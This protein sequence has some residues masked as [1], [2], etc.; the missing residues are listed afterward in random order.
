MKHTSRWMGLG[1][2]L[3]LSIIT[4][5]CPS[6]EDPDPNPP[7]QDMTPDLDNP[8]S[9]ADTPVDQPPT[10]TVAL[11]S[12]NPRSGSIHGGTV[13]TLSGA[14]FTPGAQ[15][16]FGAT[17]ATGVEVLSASQ[18]R[19]TSPAGDLGPVDVTVRVTGGAEATLSGGFTYTDGGVVTPIFCNLQPQPGLQASAGAP[20]PAIYA[21][22]FVDGVTQGLGRGD[23]LQVELGYGMGANAQNFTYSTMSYNVD[24]DGLTPGDRS[25]DEYQGTLTLPAA[26][27]F[28]YAARVRRSG[29]PDWT[30]C[31]LDGSE[32]G[33]S[34]DQLGTITVTAPSISYCQLAPQ[35]PLQARPG[36]ASAPI[37]AVV[38]AAGI[39][40]G[41]GQGQGL[42]A[43][44]GLGGV[45]DDVADFDFV[46][47]SYTADRDGLAGGDRANDEYAAALT[48]ADVGDYR[49]VAR[50]RV[51]GDADWFYCD[52]DGHGADSPFDPAQA[53]V[54]EVVAEPTP[55]IGYCLTETPTLTTR[56]GVATAP[57]RGLTYAQGI[58]DSVGAGAG[59]LAEV[60]WGP[61]DVDPSAWTAIVSAPYLEDA[62]GLNPN[63]L[64]ND[65]HAATL[66]PAN[67]GSFGYLYRFRLDA[68]A[69]WTWCGLAGPAADPD[70]IPV[71]Q[72]GQ[73]TV[74]TVNL[75][76]QCA[77]QFP[78]VI[79]DAV[80]GQPV[81]FYG[82]VFEAGITDTSDGDASL[83][84]S[85]WV[86][87]ASADPATQGALFEKLPATLN[88][89]GDF[90]NQARDEFTAT[91]TPMQAGELKFLFRFSAD[92]GQTF[93]SCDLTNTGTA[94]GVYDDRAAGVLRVSASAPPMINYCHIFQGSVI[95]APADP[96]E[97]VFTMEVYQAGVTEGDNGGANAAQLEV[98]IGYGEVGVN[99]ALMGNY[100][101]R[102]MPFARVNP[103][104]INNYEYEAPAY[105]SM[106]AA[107]LYEVVTRVRPTG[108][109]VWTYCDNFNMTMDLLMGQLSSLEILP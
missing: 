66:S 47:M 3:S 44:L 26:G 67:E 91:Y 62:D 60:V 59:I 34:E 42:E 106:P 95:K 8:D 25:N 97:P 48:A 55:T 52:L 71:A 109:Q 15:V 78:A 43:E 61:A 39:T 100:T 72:R 1:L 24:L 102:T 23:G 22:V 74:Q 31:D 33:V 90:V 38:N 103:S 2:I 86:G 41:E 70:T 69:P 9:P 50:F 89:T 18:L 37:Y 73:L 107:G 65:R 45:A 94:G 32:N 13:V 20:S 57:L 76:D 92:G 82:T 104:N 30:F 28:R 58:T 79:T 7:V 87:P 19:A 98:E 101:W 12:L 84:A 80:V 53:G 88:T 11:T 17:Q 29:D 77:I 68:S 99:P 6:E 56:P 93:R 108:E 49:Y 85:L 4:T 27:T 75:P 36:A 10:T 96:D 54:L 5:G 35:S 83:A 16:L 40:P 63:D 81:T 14:G 46:P 21:V 51:A 105:I 64:A